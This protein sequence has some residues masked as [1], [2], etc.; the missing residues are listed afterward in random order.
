MRSGCD[1]WRE[2][3]AGKKIWYDER[4]LSKAFCLEYARTFKTLNAVQDMMRLYLCQIIQIHMGI[5]RI[6]MPVVCR[7]LPVSAI[8]ESVAT[9]NS[10]ISF[11][12]FFVFIDASLVDV[13]LVVSFFL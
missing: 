9:A 2:M 7:P 6:R 5:L 13:L 11:F 8:H 4:F 1:G 10:A 3:K 12:R